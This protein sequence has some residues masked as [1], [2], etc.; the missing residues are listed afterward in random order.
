MHR[1]GASALC[2]P[3]LHPVHGLQSELNWRLSFCSPIRTSPSP[4]HNRCTRVVHQSRVGSQYRHT[5]EALGKH[6]EMLGLVFRKAQNKV[7]DLPSS[8]A[9]WWTSSLDADVKG[10]AYEGRS[11]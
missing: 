3:L 8:A 1:R 9:S 2:A 4:K 5:L 7:Q 6:M 11:T 10:H